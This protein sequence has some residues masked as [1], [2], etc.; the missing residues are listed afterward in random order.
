MR[1]LTTRILVLLV[2]LAGTL[3]AG[4]AQ[5]LA[6]D[7]ATA[8]CP[9][10]QVSLTLRWADAQDS[11]FCAVAAGVQAMPAEVVGLVVRWPDGAVS[12]LDVAPVENA[13]A[14]NPAGAS[15]VTSSS[16]SIS[17]SSSTTCINGRCTT[18]SNQL[19]CVDGVCTSQP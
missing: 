8:I 13:P 12:T 1:M 11:L 6:H 19:V 14:D 7:Q 4:S 3:A 9:R 2:L 16:R 17:S 15:T 5:A 10:G 18:S